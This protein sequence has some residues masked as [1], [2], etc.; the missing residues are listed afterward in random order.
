MLSKMPKSM[1][2]EMAGLGSFCDPRRLS[3]VCNATL[4][5]RVAVET[6]V[7]QPAEELHEMGKSKKSANEDFF[8]TDENDGY[9]SYGLKSAV[10]E[11]S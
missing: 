1:D 4:A 8:L 10:R 9:N 3:K 7:Y 2:S 11:N 6:T 5:W